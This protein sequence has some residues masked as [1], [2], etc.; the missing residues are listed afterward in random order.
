MALRFMPTRKNQQQASRYSQRLR[1]SCG[2]VRG[3]KTA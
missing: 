3:A 1:F 2:V